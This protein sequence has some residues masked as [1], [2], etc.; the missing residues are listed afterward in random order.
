MTGRRRGGSSPQGEPP[1]DGG[2]Y[3]DEEPQGP[4]SSGDDY[5]RPGDDEGEAVEAHAEFVVRHFG[6]GVEATPEILD[7]AM[8]E[9]LDRAMEVWQRLPGAVV[10]SPAQIRPNRPAPPAG[11][12]EDAT[13]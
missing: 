7:R 1:D 11:S 5:G 12:D 8:P 4:G 9:L 13:S 3:G 6:G 2:A 10:R